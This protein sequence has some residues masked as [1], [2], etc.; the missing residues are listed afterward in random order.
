MQIRILDTPGDN[1]HNGG[2]RSNS[3][4]NKCKY[5]YKY[6]ISVMGTIFE[7]IWTEVWSKS[8]SL[9][10]L[11]KG[12]WHLCH[13]LWVWK[14]QNKHLF[15]QGGSRKPKCKQHI[16]ERH[17]RVLLAKEG[18][19]QRSDGVEADQVWVEPAMMVLLI[20][21]SEQHWIQAGH[22]EGQYIFSFE[23]Q[24]F[25]TN[26]QS[27]SVLLRSKCGLDWMDVIS[28]NAEQPDSKSAWQ[29]YDCTNKVSDQ[30]Q[31]PH[32]SK[33]IMNQSIFSQLK[34]AQCFSCMWSFLTWFQ[35]QG[36]W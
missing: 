10:M 20:L 8:K 27:D 11:V 19:L 6:N 9:R 18:G 16:L 15:N 26:P 12:V 32:I 33:G 17:R 34:Q 4:S 21:T 3:G 5:K 13:R 14:A 7:P 1:V 25:H 22:N 30:I 28:L 24:I 31:C 2:R 36:S 35:Y 29:C 23:I